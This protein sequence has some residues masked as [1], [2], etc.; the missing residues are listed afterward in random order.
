MNGSN[1]IK[2][3]LLISL[4]VLILGIIITGMLF[5]MISSNNQKSKID[6][7]DQTVSNLESTINYLQN[8][9]E[10]SENDI[11]NENIIENNNK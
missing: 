6:K 5:L 9:K 10:T 4:L 7:L 11:E 3:T 8:N 2:T 1:K